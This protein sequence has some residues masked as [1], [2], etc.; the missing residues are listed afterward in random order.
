M[1]S[2]E[3]RATIVRA[4]LKKGVTVNAVAKLY[5]VNASQVYDWRK[6]AR[7]GGASSEDGEFASR[8]SGRSC[9][10]WRDRTEASR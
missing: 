6:Q 7:K 9:S 3:E 8:A 10:A 1:W 4:S 2:G 5:G